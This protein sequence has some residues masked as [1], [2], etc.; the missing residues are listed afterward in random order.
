MSVPKTYLLSDALT[1]VEEFMSGLDTS[2]SDCSCCGRVAYNNWSEKKSHEILE[3]V[4]LKLSRQLG[5]FRAELH[6]G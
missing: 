1:A 3:G 4:A 2:S 6:R 5:H